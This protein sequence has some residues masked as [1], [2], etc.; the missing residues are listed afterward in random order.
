MA[1]IEEPATEH[2]DEVTLLDPEGFPWLENGERLD[3]KTFHTR[4]LKTPERFRAELVE[5]IVYVTAS[6]VTNRH[7]R[8]LARF[9]GW[10][11]CYCAATP[12]TEGQNGATTIL[13][14][15]SETQPDSAL[16]ILSE[17]GGQSRD[18][19]DDY[20]YGAPELLIEVALSSR[21]IDLHAKFRDYERAGVREYLV[22]DL[23]KQIIHWFVLQAGRFESLVRDPDGLF[24]S[25]VFPGLWLDPD[26]FLRKDH[27]G[28]IVA[29]QRG[30]TS[31]E[32]AAF[33]AEL[34]RRHA[35]RA[36]GV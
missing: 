25:R 14:D 21:S 33:V 10:L 32:H 35:E 11:F 1:T 20:S 22:Y 18:G 16:L 23:R 17:Y 7:G 34:E 13:G 29:L 28:L 4:Y 12:G 2:H 9:S 36:G 3:Q 24:R 5:G 26:A 19:E 6:T 15:A 30:L 27:R 31:P 8:A